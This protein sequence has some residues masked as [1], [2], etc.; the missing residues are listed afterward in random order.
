MTASGA[1]KHR[2][3]LRVALLIA[4]AELKL[5]GSFALGLVFALLLVLA[6]NPMRIDLQI[7]TTVAS[8]SS[9]FDSSIGAWSA[10]LK[11]AGIDA[12]VELAADWG[13][14]EQTYLVLYRGLS[15]LQYVRYQVEVPIAP[16]LFELCA[17]RWWGYSS[18]SNFDVRLMQPSLIAGWYVA[19]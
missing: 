16:A 3:I 12:R 17:L 6:L 5:L 7:P 11:D 9:N 18:E 15:P 1:W 4:T 10:K 8:C 2:P 13:D 19:A 14:G